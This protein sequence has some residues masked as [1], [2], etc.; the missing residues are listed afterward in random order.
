[1]NDKG[2]SQQRMK[3]KRPPPPSARPAR[4][5]PAKGSIR[6]KGDA[7]RRAARRSLL[8]RSNILRRRDA[9]RRAKLMR[10]YDK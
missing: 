1:M 9:V 6:D 8:V 2:S 4:K 10:R 3:E 7:G 5:F